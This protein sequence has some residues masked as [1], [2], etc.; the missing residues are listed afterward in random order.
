MQSSPSQLQILLVE[1]EPALA[2]NVLDYLA[3]HGHQMDY[4]RDGAQGLALAQQGQYDLI[5][6]DLMLP[7]LDG[8]ALCQQL[9]HSQRST[10]VLM[11]TARDTLDDKL[12]GFAAGADDYLTKP[13]A[14]AELLV[15]CQ[16][17]ARRRQGQ[18]ALLTI[19]PLQLNRHTR[20]VWRDDQL[21]QLN[22]GCFALLQI[23]AE[24]YPAVVPRAVLLDK[25]WPDDPPDSD[26][27]RSHLYLLR[28]QLDKRFASAMLCTVHG[29]GVQLVVP[30]QLN[31][32][33]ATPTPDGKAACIT[34]SARATA[35]PAKHRAE[36]KP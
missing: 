1:D 9:R 25:L 15:R 10:P 16:A 22:P 11:L 8:L 21:L 12:A 27:L 28:Q 35:H 4:A 24:H 31:P 6:L 18:Q 5:V 2:Q 19:G 23:V 17:L 26:S 20:Q 14:L 29:V 3:L 13:F 34:K 7:Q 36:D 30:T 33:P 32:A